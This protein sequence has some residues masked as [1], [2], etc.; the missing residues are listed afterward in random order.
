ML[1]FGGNSH[2]G[3]IHML[4]DLPCFSMDFLA[5]D[6]GTVSSTETKLI[7]ER[8]CSNL[9]LV[10]ILSFAYACTVEVWAFQHM[11]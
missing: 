9:Q 4:S 1:V 2:N 7:G 3:T 10:Q 8:K 6:I 5:Y 11:S